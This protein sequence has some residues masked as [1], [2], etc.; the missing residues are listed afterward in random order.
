LFFQVLPDICNEIITDEEWL[1]QMLL[2]L[3]TNA[4][5]YTDRGSICL[6]VSV[7]N[8]HPRQFSQ[9]SNMDTSSKKSVHELSLAV[10]PRQQEAMLLI[11]VH[12]TGGFVCIY[13]GTCAVLFL[14]CCSSQSP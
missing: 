10:P 12:D 4:C 1:W 14:E 8:D 2:N 6:Q 5:K 3:L 7:L 9:S 11:E 13:L